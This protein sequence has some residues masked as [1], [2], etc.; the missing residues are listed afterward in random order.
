MSD[1]PNALKAILLENATTEQ[2]K[3]FAEMLA[4]QCAIADIQAK[5]HRCWFFVPSATEWERMKKYSEPPNYDKCPKC[6]KGRLRVEVYHGNIGSSWN[7]VCS[8]CDFKEYIS[9]DE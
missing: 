1:N 3:E 6:N 5:G 8:K 4:S 9:D 7:L 2:Q